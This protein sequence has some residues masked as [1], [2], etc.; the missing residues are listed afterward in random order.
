MALPL[1]L[2]FRRLRAGFSIFH[3]DA[4]IGH[5]GRLQNVAFRV[6]LG[7]LVVSA[8]SA[9]GAVGEIALRA[10]RVTGHRAG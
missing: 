8:V 7:L 4:L 10:V 5:V 3:K 1:L 9:L 2:S 6:L